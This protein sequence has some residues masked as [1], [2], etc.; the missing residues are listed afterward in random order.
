MLGID[1]NPSDRILRQFAAAWAAAFGVLAARQW[2][3]RGDAHGAEA[4]VAAAL[5]GGVA[6]LVRPRTMRWLFVGCTVAAFP[7]GWVVSQLMLFVLFA[8]VIT[9]LA[10]VL[11]RQGRDRLGRTRSEQASYWRPKAPVRDM[12]RYLRQY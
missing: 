7:I 12:R 5:L 11:K 4:L 2:F 8:F 3:L 9:P 6:G 1:L 10:W